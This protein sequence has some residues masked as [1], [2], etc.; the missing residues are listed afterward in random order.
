MC[1]NIEFIKGQN[2]V[3]VHVYMHLLS[4][5]S[6]QEHTR[7]YKHFQALAGGYDFKKQDP[8]ALLYKLDS[9]V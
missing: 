1:R 6:Y 8:T 4:R 3:D 5:F 7:R 2:V 9:L